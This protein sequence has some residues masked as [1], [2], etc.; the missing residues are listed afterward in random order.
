MFAVLWILFL[1]LMIWIGLH[2]I[3]GLF[4]LLGVLIV[5]GIAGWLAGHFMRGRGYGVLKDILLGFVG[6]IVGGI[7][8]ALA[9]IHWHGILGS[10]VTAT[11]GAVVVLYIARALR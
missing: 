5:G 4:S 6:G 9:G 10:I 2:I 7:L 8:F 3:G 1:V 11:I